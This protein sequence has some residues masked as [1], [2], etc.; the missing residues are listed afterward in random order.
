MSGATTSVLTMEHSTIVRAEL[1]LVLEEAGFSVCADAKTGAE[2]IE[3]ARQFDPDVIVLDLGKQFE[4]IETTRRILAEREIPIIALSG[5]PDARLH[6]AVEAGAT[7]CLQKPYAVPD[8]V[9]AVREAVE[10][11][12]EAGALQERRAQSLAALSE[13]VQALG[14]PAAW[15]TELEQR[16][17]ARGHAWR[18]VRRA[19][20]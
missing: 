7:A 3:L 1:R 4:G 8:L 18:I 16:A 17:F 2:A 6:E 9:D 11:T 13:L 19:A 10:R 5:H 15:A 20:P 14:Y 12:D